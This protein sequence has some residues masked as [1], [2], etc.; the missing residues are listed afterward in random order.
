LNSI[1]LGVARIIE[2]VKKKKGEGKASD[3]EKS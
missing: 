1:K 2:G 3:R